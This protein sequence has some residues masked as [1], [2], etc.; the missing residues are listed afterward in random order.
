[1]FPFFILSLLLFL[2]ISVVIV[3]GLMQQSSGVIEEVA[4]LWHFPSVFGA[5]TALVLLLVCIPGGPLAPVIDSMK[6]L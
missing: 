6:N 1:M 4:G 5:L 3:P 2:I